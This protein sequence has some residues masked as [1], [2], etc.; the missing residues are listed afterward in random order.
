M[1]RTYAFVAFFVISFFAAFHAYACEAAPPCLKREGYSALLANYLAIKGTLVRGDEDAAGQ[2]GVAMGATLSQW[3]DVDCLQALKESLSAYQGAADISERRSVFSSLSE[4]VYKLAKAH[5]NE[6]TLYKQYCP[7]ALDSRG[8]GW[9]S[10][11]KKIENP[12]FGAAMLKCG[13][14]KE[15]IE[16]AR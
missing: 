11:S 3:K 16:V 15:R 7:M 4:E 13:S 9:L 2:M 1:R 14:V 6:Q 12:Y 10:L 5:P 8:A